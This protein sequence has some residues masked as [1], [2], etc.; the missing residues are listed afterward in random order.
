[1]STPL[2]TSLR[3]SCGYLR[4]E[5]WHQT[6]R[7]MTVAA[8]EIESLGVRIRELEQH[9]RTLDETSGSFRAPEASNQNAA[10]SVAASSQR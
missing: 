6:A 4:D 7:L 9:L 10:H 8:T 3:E 5:G 2:I 1:M